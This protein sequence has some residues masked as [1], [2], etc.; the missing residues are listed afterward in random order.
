M[1]TAARLLIADG[2]PL[3]REGLRL[4]ASAA[5]PLMVIDTAAS[6][7]EVERLTKDNRYHLAVLDMMLPGSRGFSC[8]LQ[9]QHRL[10]L[11]PVILISDIWSETQIETANALGAAGYLSRSAPLDHVAEALRRAL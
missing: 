10:A 1:G 5:I 9:L 3:E 2:N 4:I 11:A 6:A 7:T 8:L